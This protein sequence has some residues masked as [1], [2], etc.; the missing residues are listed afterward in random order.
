M[1]C[2]AALSSLQQQ[3]QQ[4]RLQHQQ[5][6]TARQT[7]PMLLGHAARALLLLL[8]RP[9]RRRRPLLSWPLSQLAL[10]PSPWLWLLLAAAQFWLQQQADLLPCQV[11]PVRRRQHLQ[12]P[13]KPPKK[14][15]CRQ[16]LPRA[17]L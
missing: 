8:P 17:S 7:P 5:A 4:R 11:A 3:Q 6:L 9:G 12:Q 15:Q 14:R 1:A 16:A 2:R 13:P 10:L